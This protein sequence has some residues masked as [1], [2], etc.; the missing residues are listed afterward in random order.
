LKPGPGGKFLDGDA[1]VQVG[2]PAQVGDTEAALTEHPAD[3]VLA[4]KQCAWAKVKA[5]SRAI[6]RGIAAIG[7]GV[8]IAL[9]GKTAVAEVS[10][11][12]LKCLSYKN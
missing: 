12:H 3:Q 6:V 5:C 11:F 2:V 9:V 8:L 10:F 7:A 4:K 1:D